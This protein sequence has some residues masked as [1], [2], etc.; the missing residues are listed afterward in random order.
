[1]VFVLFIKMTSLDINKEK[2]Y[3][4]IEEVLKKIRH[5]KE[6]LWLMNERQLFERAK[7]QCII[8]KRKRRENKITPPDKVGGKIM[9]TR[10][11]ILI[12]E[13]IKWFQPI[14]A[15]ANGKIKE[16]KN[17]EDIEEILI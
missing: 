8:D 17:V 10:Q 13:F 4:T 14:D 16:E 1:M 3:Y 5:T 15:D 9:K 2:S 6:P 12:K 11:T 7:L